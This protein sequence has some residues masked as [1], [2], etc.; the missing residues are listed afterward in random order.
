MLFDLDWGFSLLFVSSD[1]SCS[2]NTE[3]SLEVNLMLLPSISE[4]NAPQKI[5]TQENWRSW[6][7]D[8]GALHTY[9]TGGSCERRDEES[10]FL[11]EMPYICF[12]R[13]RLPLMHHSVFR[14]HRSFC[15][16]KQKCF[17]IKGRLLTQ[18]LRSIEEL[19]TLYVAFAR[20]CFVPA[21][22]KMSFSIPLQ[23]GAE[24][25]SKRSSQCWTSCYVLKC[26]LIYFFWIIVCFS[27]VVT[28]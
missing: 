21:S 7:E 11:S 6:D 12:R 28:P 10:F 17:I 1:W 2:L 23:E 18:N 22:A 9:K 16:Q 3:Y 26:S 8:Q 15:L 14:K 27:Q 20:Y 25:R 5:R 4:S 13:V 19:L 24:E